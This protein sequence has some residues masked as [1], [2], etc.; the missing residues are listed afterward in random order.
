M[1]PGLWVRVPPGVVFL[2]HLLYIPYNSGVVSST[3]D[4]SQDS[5]HRSWCLLRSVWY[6]S[7]LATKSACF[8]YIQVWMKGFQFVHRS[9][10][11]F[12]IGSGTFTRHCDTP[13]N[14]KASCSVMN[15]LSVTSLCVASLHV[16]L[17][18]HVKARHPLR[19]RCGMCYPVNIVVLQ[20]SEVENRREFTHSS[21]PL[22][23]RHSNN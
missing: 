5:S 9:S 3:T 12:Q 7:H 17:Y 21:E 2:L 16:N 6:V 18:S 19:G 14:C 10:I 13:P 20:A 4:Q 8:R 23:P 22:S 15:T 11:S 1:L